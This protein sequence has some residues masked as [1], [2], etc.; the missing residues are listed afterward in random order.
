MSAECFCH[1]FTLSL[2]GLFSTKVEPSC[3][4]GQRHSILGFSCL[5]FFKC[6]VVG[7]WKGSDVYHISIFF[8]LGGVW[9]QDEMSMKSF[10]TLGCFD[11]SSLVVQKSPRTATLVL[12]SPS[13]IPPP[14]EPSSFDSEGIFTEFSQASERTFAV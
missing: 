13:R 1:I 6:L 10:Y 14:T 9:I 4:P 12:Q 5:I 3:G 2:F 7:V 11:S 8:F